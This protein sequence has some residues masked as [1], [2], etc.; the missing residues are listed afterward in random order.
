MRMY[1]DTSSDNLRLGTFF[2]NRRMR[3]YLGTSSGNLCLVGTS[4]GSGCQGIMSLEASQCF[5]R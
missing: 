1:L 5:I 2:G 4:A 3:M